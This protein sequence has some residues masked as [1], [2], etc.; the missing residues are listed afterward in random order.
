M[1]VE[2]CE[3]AR[4]NPVVIGVVVLTEATPA[5]E[6]V[7]GARSYSRY[8]LSGREGEVA[9][10]LIMRLSNAEIAQRLGISEHTAR[11]H[12]QH[13][14]DKLGVSARRHIAAALAEPAVTAG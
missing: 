8:R 4:T 3:L 10:L 5:Q 2:A 9:E 13:I 7:Q 1:R 14:L 12:V 6:A 11:N